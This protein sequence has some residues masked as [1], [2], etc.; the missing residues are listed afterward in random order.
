M[1][2]QQA[3]ER[4]RDSLKQRISACRQRLRMSRAEQRE[5]V[6]EEAP[7]LALPAHVKT[8]SAPVDNTCHEKLRSS[9]NPPESRY[10]PSGTRS[11]Y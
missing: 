11:N 8:P 2:S 4:S 9:T 5:V 3:N 6:R 10:S 1:C 7:G